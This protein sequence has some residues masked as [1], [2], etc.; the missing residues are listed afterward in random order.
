MTGPG[1]VLRLEVPGEGWWQARNSPTRRVPSHGTDL[2]GT[3]YALDL[4]GVDDRGR[5]GPVGWR[6]ILATESA[7]SFVGFGRPVI[8]PVEGVVATTRDG[9]PDGRARRSPLAYP[10]F[11]LTQPQWARRGLAGL[12]GNCVVIAPPSGGFVVVAHLMRGSITVGPGQHVVVG[13]VIGR[14]GNSGNSVQPHVHLQLSDSVDRR[15]ARGLP[16]VFGAFRLPDGTLRHDALP[17]EGETICR[18]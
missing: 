6:T 3:S 8:A 7:E 15:D 12:A 9:E 10:R 13:A 18:T 17:A 11:A 1:S 4:V 5:S 2:F 14:V 16:F